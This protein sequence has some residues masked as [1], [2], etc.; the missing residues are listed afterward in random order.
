[1]IEI[2]QIP[3]TDEMKKL[4]FEGFSRHAIEEN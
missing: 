1:M 2:S 4:I 3:L